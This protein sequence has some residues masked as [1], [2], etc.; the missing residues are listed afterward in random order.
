MEM[1]APS[2][3]THAPA[4]AGGTSEGERGRAPVFSR[5]EEALA[6]VGR[7][8]TSGLR[9]RGTATEAVVGTCSSSSDPDSLGLGADR[10]P[11]ATGDKATTHP[12]VRRRIKR[13]DT[14]T[15]PKA[16]TAGDSG[17]CLFA[18]IVAM[19]G[20]MCVTSQ[21]QQ[22]A[23]QRRCGPRYPL[24]SKR[25]CHCHSRR[26]GPPRT[27]HPGATRVSPDLRWTRTARGARRDSPDARPT[28]SR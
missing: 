16:R 26:G 9:E 23:A 14:G 11:D 7:E 25:K 27:S 21:P 5:G 13:P 4:G 15:A 8:P 12:T 2:S 18:S 6:A 28:D 20:A 3:F 17:W 10:Y 24:Q 1:P 19:M 22:G